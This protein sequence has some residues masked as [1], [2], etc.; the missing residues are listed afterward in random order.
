MC[1]MRSLPVRGART[2]TRDDHADRMRPVVARP[3]ADGNQWP[4]PAPR[5]RDVAPVRGGLETRH[6]GR[7]PRRSLSPPVRGRGLKLH[8]RVGYALQGSRPPSG[9]GI[10]TQ[11]ASGHPAFRGRSSGAD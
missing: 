5:V 2:E 3:G 7:C 8:G 4:R 6:P 10:E 1:W 11:A 9:G